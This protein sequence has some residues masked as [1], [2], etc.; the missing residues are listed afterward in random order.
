MKLRANLY[1]P[2]LMIEIGEEGV[3]SK[4]NSTPLR[5]EH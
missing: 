4:K 5:I 2:Y 3:E 1:L